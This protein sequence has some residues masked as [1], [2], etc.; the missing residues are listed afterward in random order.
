VVLGL[1]G[2]LA[3][4]HLSYAL[5]CV[6][7]LLLGMALSHLVHHRLDQ[8]RLRL[9]VLLFATVSGIAVMAAG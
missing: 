7:A 2:S 4:S 9:G 8:R 5:L 1:S 6:P 3:W